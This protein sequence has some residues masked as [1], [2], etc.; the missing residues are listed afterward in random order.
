MD[1][2]KISTIT[3]RLVLELLEA[4]SLQP[5]E[6]ETLDPITVTIGKQKITVQVSIEVA[7]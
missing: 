7:E 1:F 4:K 6:T 3:S 2:G 5:G